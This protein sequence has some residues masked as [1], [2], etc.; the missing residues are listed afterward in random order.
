L[1]N[2]GAILVTC[3]WMRSWSWDGI[4][5]CPGW[6][7][8]SDQFAA[9]AGNCGARSRKVAYLLHLRQ[10]LLTGHC[11]C[12]V[13]ARNQK[14]VFH[15]G[16][17]EVQKLGPAIAAQPAQPCVL[18]VCFSY[19]SWLEDAV[20]LARF[21]LESLSLWSATCTWLCKEMCHHFSVFFIMIVFSELCFRL[22]HRL[23]GT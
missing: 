1:V 22:K 19:L 15:V 4:A 18:C 12:D 7:V 11:S 5:P 2:Q 6:A 8:C 23:N 9:P 13:T 20:D 17:E 3:M 16:R 21:T 14:K 10:S